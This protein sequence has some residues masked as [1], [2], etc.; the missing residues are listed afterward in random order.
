MFVFLALPPITTCPTLF[1]QFKMRG[2]GCRGKVQKESLACFAAE[3]E[4]GKQI[5]CRGIIDL[6]E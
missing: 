1:C 6:I 2:V 3:E 5:F 4:R